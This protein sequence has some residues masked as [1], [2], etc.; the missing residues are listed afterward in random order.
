MQD[1]INENR[2]NKTKSSNKSLSHS[3]AIASE[4]MG[5]LGFQMAGPTANK[6][7]P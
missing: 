1:K 4:L 5:F 2:K 7:T 6:Q 3:K